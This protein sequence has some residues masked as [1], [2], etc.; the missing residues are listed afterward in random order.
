MRPNRYRAS[1]SCSK[2]SK[3]SPD[4]AAS[5]RPE[6]CDASWRAAGV[7]RTVTELTANFAGRSGCKLHILCNPCCPESLSEASHPAIQL[8]ES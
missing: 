2:Y 4:L 7:S 5:D 6:F 8:L 1:T 3:S